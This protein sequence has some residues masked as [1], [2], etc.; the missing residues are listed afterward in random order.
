M[1]T[2]E[3]ALASGRGIERPFQC[4]EHDDRSAS[5]SVNVVKGVWYCFSCSARGVVDGD[6]IPTA[7]ELLTMLEPETACRDYA[8]SW[9]EVYGVGGYWLDRFPAWLCS[10]MQLGEDPWTGEGVFPV[11]TAHGRLAGLARR[12][13]VAGPGPKYRYPWTWSASRSL[14]GSRGLWHHQDIVTLVEGAADACALHEVGVP[15]H[16]VYGS[17]L[18]APQVDLVMAMSPRL[19]LLGFDSDEAGERATEQTYAALSGLVQVGVLRWEAGKD[20][21]DCSPEQRLETVLQTVGAASY[22]VTPQD[23]A[24]HARRYVA[25]AKQFYVEENQRGE[26]SS[27]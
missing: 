10:Q 23:V 11:H 3:E 2:L 24:K 4:F 14:F 8:S 26:A 18:H 5:A 27:N 12:A 15:A 21:A 16:A 6:R 7:D 25:Q 22:G 13:L 19:V 1:S 17:G 9:W 20:P